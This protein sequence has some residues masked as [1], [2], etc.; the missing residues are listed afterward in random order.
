MGVGLF[1]RQGAEDAKDA[2]VERLTFLG[3]L[4]ELGGLG[5]EMTVRSTDSSSHPPWEL[6]FASP[7][8]DLGSRPQVTP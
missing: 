1:R 8:G 6:V 7:G 5:V 2:K 4:G 3:G